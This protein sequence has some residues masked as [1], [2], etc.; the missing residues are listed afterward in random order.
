MTLPAPSLVVAPA[1]SRLSVRRALA[2]VGMLASPA[3]LVQWLADGP[4]AAA[5]A[6]QVPNVRANAMD[7]VYLAGFAASVVGL[8]R[9]RA[10]GAGRGAAVLFAVQLVGLCLA[11][12]QDLQ[13]LAGV[14]ALGGAFYAAADVA[15]P[16]SHVLMLVVFA[17]VWRARVWT[18]WRRW[19]PLACGLVVPVMIAAA[20]IGGRTAMG[21]VFCPGTAVAF[22]ALGLAVLTAPSTGAEA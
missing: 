7:L 4:F 9:L 12:S 6:P 11:A 22:F 10:T 14:R 17:A 19:T 5:A 13:D 1:A 15:W 18:G 20:A 8:R 21:F 16:V 3:F 2:V